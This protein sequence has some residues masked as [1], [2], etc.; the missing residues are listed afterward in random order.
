L[1]FPRSFFASDTGAFAAAATGLVFAPFVGAVIAMGFAFRFGFA[2]AT[3]FLW[4][5]VPA[6]SMQQASLL[7]SVL[8]LSAQD[9]S[10]LVHAL[11]MLPLRFPFRLRAFDRLARPVSLSSLSR[12]FSTAALRPI[13]V[14]LR[15]LAG[16]ER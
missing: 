13:S 10:F 5:S 2:G 15:S 9:A 8:P 11:L 3:G 12:A 14:V 1:V 4:V 7:F 6:L 16:H